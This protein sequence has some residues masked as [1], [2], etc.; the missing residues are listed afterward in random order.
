ME[1]VIGI[2]IDFWC[3]LKPNHPEGELVRTVD[4]FWRQN[5]YDPSITKMDHLIDQVSEKVINDYIN[6]GCLVDIDADDRHHLQKY[7]RKH[8]YFE[9]KRRMMNCPI[10]DQPD[11]RGFYWIGANISQVVC[12]S[13]HPGSK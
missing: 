9:R 6:K 11:S 5:N 8:Q 2:L 10:C 3:K 1:Y 7:P 4:L 13:K 12:M